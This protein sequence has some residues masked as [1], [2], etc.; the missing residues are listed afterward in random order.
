MM[1]ATGR[2]IV[3]GN[4]REKERGSVNARGSRLAESQNVNANVT[5][6]GK[7]E[8]NELNL[9]TELLVTNVSNLAL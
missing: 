5:E 9:P 3:I 6:R 7:G 8:K 2:G 4:V 1:T